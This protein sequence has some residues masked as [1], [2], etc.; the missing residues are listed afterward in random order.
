MKTLGRV[1]R[2]YEIRSRC[3]ILKLMEEKIKEQIIRKIARKYSLDLLLLFGSRAENKIHQE[4]DFD[5]AYLSGQKLDLENEAQLATDLAPV[6]GT[7]NIDLVNVKMTK[8]LLFYAV[9][10]NCQ[11][12]YAKN[13]MIFPAL[14]AYAFKKY[15]ET[16]PLYELKFKR[17]KEKILA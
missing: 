15:V 7:D 2:R 16:K 11:V 3:A 9:F 6:F 1:F 8:P 13:P 10:K 17:L 14:R 12:L 4:S 5:I